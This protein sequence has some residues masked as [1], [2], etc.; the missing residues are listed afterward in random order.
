MIFLT[1][2][3]VFQNNKTHNIVTHIYKKDIIQIVYTH[4]HTHIYIYGISKIS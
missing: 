1:D 4:T 3:Q 2:F